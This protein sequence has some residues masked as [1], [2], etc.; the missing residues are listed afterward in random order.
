MIFESLAL[1]LAYLDRHMYTRY[2]FP[3]KALK[4]FPPCVRDNLDGN[5]SNDPKQIIAWA[6]K[7]PGC[8]WGVAHAKSKLLVADVDTNKT[9]GKVGDETFAVLDLIYGWDATERTET[10]SGGWHMVYQ[11]WA[12]ENHPAHVM[13]L[14]LNGIGKDIDSPNYTLIPGCVFAD[15]TSYTTNDAD[16]V[17]CPQWIYDTIKN[18]K[19]KSRIANAGE[20]VVELDQPANIELAIDFLLQ[21]AVPAIEGSGGD[22]NT[23]KTAMYLK[24]IGISPAVSLDILCEYYNPRCVPEWDRDDMERKVENAFNYASLSKTG[25]KTAEADFADDEPEINPTR[26]GTYNRETKT[27]EF[28]N[29]ADPDT[30]AEAR[31][32]ARQEVAAQSPEKRER[33]LK[34]NEL[35]KEWVWVG[36]LKRFIEKGDTTNVWDKEAFNGQYNNILGSK[37]TKNIADVLLRRKKGTIARFKSVAYKPGLDQRISGDVFNMYVPPNITPAEGDVSWWNDHL[38]YLF[39][40]EED[41]MMVMNWMAWLLQNLTEKPKHALLIQGDAQGTGKS[42]IVEMLGRI[43][44]LRNVANI[45]QSDLHGDFN[46]WAIRSKLLVIEELRAIDKTEVAN[47]LHPLITQDMISVNEKNLPQRNVENC[48]GIFAMSNHEAALNLDDTDRRYLVINTKATPRYGKNSPA[49]IAY[50]TNLYVTKLNDPAAIAAVAYQLGNW[51]YGT[52]SGASA[53]PLT[54]AKTSMIAA[55]QDE[56]ARWMEDQRDIFPFNGRLVALDDIAILVPKRIEHRAPRLS[57]NIRSILL[58]KFDAE[59]MG[60]AI[61]ANGARPRLYAINGKGGILKNLTPKPLGAI[62]EADKQKAGKG[63]PIDDDDDNATN[64]FGDPQE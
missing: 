49:S 34:E 50:Y 2:I 21:D 7:F 53:A 13:A 32:A 44:N 35:I 55:G 40:L 4:K 12:D 5:C 6:K 22:F 30:A 51:D 15:G 42:Y 41:R 54:A 37:S 26:M 33:F 14:G 57:A 46:G 43:L 29:S 59:E 23:L 62:Y 9:K 45:N 17:N 11:G 20:V 60:Q 19:A 39:P 28:T 3:I 64:E 56:L 27:Y 36:G 52:Y 8:N 10:P 31:A 38:E 24:D 48:F 47:K 63:K 25:G 1:A 16:A 18:S 58:R 61:L